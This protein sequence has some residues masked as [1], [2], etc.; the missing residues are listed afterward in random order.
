MGTEAV[1][2]LASMGADSMASMMH[3]ADRANYLIFQRAPT[4]ITLC[5]AGKFGQST[6]GVTRVLTTTDGGSISVTP[7]ASDDLS[8]FTGF[9]EVVGT[10]TA[11]G[12]LQATSVLP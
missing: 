4:G 1:P 11:D 10:K 5:I 9:V 3:V 8:R 12:M 6:A 7:Q 2:P